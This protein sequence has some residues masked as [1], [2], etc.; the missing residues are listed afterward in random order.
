MYVCDMGAQRIR[1]A[2]H[3][4]QLSASRSACSVMQCNVRSA[5]SDPIPGLQRVGVRGSEEVESREFFER[6]LVRLESG[7]LEAAAHDAR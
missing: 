6:L 5:V 2:R 3:T 1:I 7:D 4:L